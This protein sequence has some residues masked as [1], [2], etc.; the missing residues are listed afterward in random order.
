MNRIAN[1]NFRGLFFTKLMLTKKATKLQAIE[2]PILPI[3]PTQKKE[4]PKSGHKFR[5][6]LRIYHKLTEE[7]QTSNR[8]TKREFQSHKPGLHFKPKLLKTNE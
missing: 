8:M 7:S 5:L 2:P 4:R 3:I 1:L 6:N